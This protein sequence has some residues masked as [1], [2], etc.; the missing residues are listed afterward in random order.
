[1]RSS[2]EE[3]FAVQRR[4]GKKP[5]PTLH[6][7][8]L[9]QC[10]L[11]FLGWVPRRGSVPLDRRGAVEKACFNTHTTRLAAFWNAE[12]GATG[13]QQSKRGLQAHHCLG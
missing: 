9:F 12:W 7:G 11:I 5:R 3:A 6:S 10:L 4:T 13:D 2:V 1:M 8:A